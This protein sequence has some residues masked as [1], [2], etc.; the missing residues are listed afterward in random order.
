MPLTIL[1]EAAHASFNNSIDANVQIAAGGV[2]EENQGEHQMAVQSLLA[3]PSADTSTMPSTDSTETGADLCFQR[4][5]G[6]LQLYV[7]AEDVASNY[8][9]NMYSVDEVH[10]IA[11]LDLRIFNLDRNDANILV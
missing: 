11:I 9:Y 4:K 7:D 6:S 1:V 2:E 3:R 8:S 10:K 5:Y